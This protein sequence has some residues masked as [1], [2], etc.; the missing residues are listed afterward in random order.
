[1]NFPAEALAMLSKVITFVVVQGSE[2]S[3]L[4]TVVQGLHKV[5]RIQEEAWRLNKD[6]G[7]GWGSGETVQVFDKYQQK[8][9]VGFS[10]AVKVVHFDRTTPVGPTLKHLPRSPIRARSWGVTK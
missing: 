6:D 7:N 8:S 1:L 4:V 5:V 3:S 9:G 2:R 10:G